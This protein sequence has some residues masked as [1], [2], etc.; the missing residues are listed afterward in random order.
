MGEAKRILIEQG[1]PN[2]TDSQVMDVSK[3]IAG[4]SGV[5]VGEWDMTGSPIDTNM[6]A[7]TLLHIGKAVALAAR[8][9]AGTP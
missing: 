2:P 9:V 8:M 4:D 5:G 6:K 7:G 3:V 1:V